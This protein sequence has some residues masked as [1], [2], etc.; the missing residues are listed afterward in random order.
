MKISLRA[1]LTGLWVFIVALCLALSILMAGLYRLG[2]EAQVKRVEAE[3]SGAASELAQRFGASRKNVANPLDAGSRDERGRELSL[4]V[5]LVLA[6]HHGVEGGF[7]SG[8]GGALAYG[9]PTYEGGAEKT[10]VPSAELPRIAEIAGS[11]LAVKAPRAARYAGESEVLVICAEPI[12]TAGLAAWTMS[13]AHV[14]TAASYEK[15]RLGFAV[16]LAF[17]LLSGV[18]LIRFLQRWSRK[19]EVLETALS[20]APSDEPA[21]LPETGQADLDRIVVSFNSLQGRLQQARS[22]A[23]RL[24]RELARAERTSALGRMAAGVAHEIRNP[25]AAMRLRAENAR[26]SGAHNHD[27]ALEFILQEIRRLDEL[28]ERLLAI[29]RIERID[30]AVV[31]LRPW[32]LDLAAVWQERAQSGAVDL[33]VTAPAASAFFDKNAMRRV[34]EN[35]L[36]NALQHTPASG[37]IRLA[38]ERRESECLFVVEN[39]G[40]PIP[41]ERREQVFEPFSTGRPSGTGLG[42][43]IAREIVDAHGGQIRCVESAAGAR[44]EVELPC[45]E[46]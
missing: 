17:S 13:R 25:I 16:L 40:E 7:W 20:R 31:A 38:G 9:F 2:V 33:E 46:C 8:E 26:A 24:S 3:V 39:S 44:F 45:P 23:G 27:A 22:D 29:A 5:S 37:W 36:Q 34:L 41:A 14:S 35:L 10:D 21:R 4:I 18:G 32:L 42:L 1:L 28:L 43:S 6:S 19:V 30:P 15:L 12:P 11:A